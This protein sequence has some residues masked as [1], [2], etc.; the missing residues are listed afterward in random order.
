MCHHCYNNSNV[1]LRIGELMSLHRGQGMDILW[2]D[3]LRC[4]TEEEYVDMV[5]ASRLSSLCQVPFVKNFARNGWSPQDCRQTYDGM[6]YDEHKC[7][8]LTWSPLMFLN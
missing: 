4:P 1:T 5:R 8:S 3:T 7:V 6:C 2:R